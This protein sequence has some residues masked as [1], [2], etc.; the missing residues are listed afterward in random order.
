MGSFDKLVCF[1]CTVARVESLDS[2]AEEEEIIS[3]SWAAV[4]L[5]TNQVQIYYFRAEM[6]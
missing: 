6:V 3:L 2:E 1:H 5:K 4:D